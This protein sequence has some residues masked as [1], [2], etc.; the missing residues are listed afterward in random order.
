LAILKIQNKK[1]TEI[2]VLSHYI[3]KAMVKG[4]LPSLIMK[5]LMDMDV[6]KKLIDKAFKEA[7]EN[8]AVGKLCPFRIKNEE[9]V[10]P[11]VSYLRIIL[12]SDIFTPTKLLKAVKQKGWSKQELDLALSL[13]KINQKTLV[14]KGTKKPVKKKQAKKKISQKKPAI[15]IKKKS[16][17]KK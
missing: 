11:L 4:I 10:K 17:K 3:Q 7:T 14:K 15:A 6:E 12:P 9:I 16:V 2:H 8:D 5:D 1:E 13:L